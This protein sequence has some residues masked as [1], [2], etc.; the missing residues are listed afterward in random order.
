MDSSLACFLEC[1]PDSPLVQHLL[2][3]WRLTL[4]FVSVCIAVGDPTLKLLDDHD[5]NPDTDPNNLFLNT[6]DQDL[7]CGTGAVQFEHLEPPFSD[8]DYMFTLSQTEGIS[9]LFDIDT[10]DINLWWTLA[11][12]SVYSQINLWRIMT[13]YRVPTDTGKPGKIRQLFPVREKSGNFEKIIKSQG[14]VREF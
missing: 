12:G 5:L 7:D 13:N 10:C 3:V 9:D 4:M 6:V 8:D 1:D 14:K 11:V 2:T